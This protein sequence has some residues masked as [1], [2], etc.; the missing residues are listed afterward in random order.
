MSGPKDFQSLLLA[1]QTYW[2]ERGCALMQGYDLEV[3]AGTMNPATFL[4]VLGP[5]P[6]NVAYIE[7][8][9]RPADGRFGENPMRLFKHHQFQVILKPSPDEVQQ[10]YL[11]SLEA[12]GIN[13]RQ[14]DIRFEE[15]N[16][17]SPT[18]GA[19][20]IGWQVLLDGLEIT[21]F[22]YFQQVGGIDLSPISAEITYGIERIAMFLQKKDNV[23]EI[24]WG[25]G[26]TYGDVRMRDEVEQSKYAFNQDTG[27]SRE[28]FSSFHRT[29]FDENFKFGEELMKGGLLLPALE[30]CLRCSHLFNLLDSSGSVG[31]TERTAYILRVRQLAVGIAKYWVGETS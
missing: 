16:W 23:F 20:G 8:S 11:D 12:C 13:P 18:L 28:R 14:H 10:T 30:H 19:W 26:K 21:Q 7:P 9:R 17:E 4:R 27:I 22:T 29:Q 2:A 25:G 15:D 6:W 3:G 31:V 24:E 1:L 5:E